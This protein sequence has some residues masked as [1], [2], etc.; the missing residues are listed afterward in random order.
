MMFRARMRAA[1]WAATVLAAG[2]TARAETVNIHIDAT[3]AVK[4]ISRYIYGVNGA[5]GGQHA[6]LTFRRVGG[7][8]WTAYNW[9][10]N[11]SNAGSDFIF[12][13]DDYLGGGNVPGGATIP[14]IKNASAAKGALL[15]TIP[16]QGY[17]A[18][19]KNGDGDVRNTPNYLQ[20]R[21][22]QE[23]AAK[24]A[25][26]TF[27]PPNT[28]IY[29]DEFVNWV[30]SKFPYSQ[31]DP[32]RPIWFCLDNEPD[33][34]AETH[35]EVHPAA[36]TYAEMVTKSP[37]YAKAIKAVAPNTLVFG[38]VSYGWYG[39]TRLQGA[40]DANNR[41]FLLYYLQKMKAASAA[42]HKRL[43]D[44]LD[45]HWYPEAQSGNN[46]NG[47]RITGSETTAAVVAA[48][49]QAPRSLWD[50]TYQENSWITRDDIQQPI[51]LIP[52][53]LKK[54]ASGYPGT[55][56]AFTEYNYGAGQH[57]SGGIAQADVLGAFG[58]Y[59][60]FAAS[61]WPLLAKEPFVTAA[62]KMYRDY[63]GNNGSFGNISVK[64]TTS[65]VADTSVYASRDSA[66]ANR[67]VVVALNKTDHAITANA[68]LAHANAL[69]GGTAY[70]LTA[71]AAAP[72]PAGALATSA[73]GFSYV[74]PAYSV[75]TLVLTTH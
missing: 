12:Q 37:A 68:T 5:L 15:L 1:I 29:Q 16:I 6:N 7:N 11:A 64:A 25:A 26:F 63:D 34:W 46:A 30:K 19:D 41:D 23:Q 8:R 73:S 13:N 57:I 49:L 70:K 24:G 35:L 14:A 27:N 60:V 69:A 65:S 3:A 10:N 54:I 67:I 32:M 72:K 9:V 38:P 61:Q 52:R 71:A 48:R 22:R 31:T 42:A 44:V 50:P 17:V 28:T 58:R 39:F 47:I 2:A 74:M 18:A 51:Q 20:V 53:M 55:K 56:L 43:L 45:L 21:F 62:F 33:L 4:P 40:P 36:P 59:G 66:H 75:N